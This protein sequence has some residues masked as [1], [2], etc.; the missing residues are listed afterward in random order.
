MSEVMN[1]KEDELKESLIEAC[2]QDDEEDLVFLKR[3]TSAAYNE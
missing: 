2:E 1:Q 3:A